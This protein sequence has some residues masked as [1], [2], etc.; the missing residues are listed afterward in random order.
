MS[1]AGNATTSPTSSRPVGLERPSRRSRKT[2]R[3]PIAAAHEVLSKDGLAGLTVKAVT[4]RADVGHGTFYHHFESAEHVLGA[5]VEASM[6]DLAEELVHQHS[7]AK[8]KAWVVVDSTSSL[9]EMLSNH[10]AQGWMLERPH[11]MASALRRV[12]GP[13]VRQDVEALAASTAIEVGDIQ[14]LAPFWAWMMIGALAAL[15]ES[16]SAHRQVERDLVEAMLRLIGLD[17]TH[18]R[19]LRRRLDARPKIRTARAT[20]AGARR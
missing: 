1:D 15:Q 7:N 20:R 8:D 14:R 9:F 18:L 17:T 5:A 3:E 6:H 4:A 19:R 12:V 16:P 11:I 13:Y 10:P 2:S